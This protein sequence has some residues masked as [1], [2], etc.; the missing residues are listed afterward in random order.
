MYVC[1]FVC[2]PLSNAGN[3]DGIQTSEQAIQ[4]QSSL[5][6]E[7]ERTLTISADFANL[8]RSTAMESLMDQSWERASQ[9]WSLVG[10]MASKYGDSCQLGLQDLL[11]LTRSAMR[12]LE[13]YRL[14]SIGEV[15]AVVCRGALASRE[16]EL[17]EVGPRQS[18]AIKGN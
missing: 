7:L 5:I 8:F 2:A 16:H 18:K 12:G 13:S 17:L 4:L 1:I 3:T 14:P 9:G 10:A 6:A 11:D 15:L